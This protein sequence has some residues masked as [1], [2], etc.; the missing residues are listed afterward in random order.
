[1]PERTCPICYQDQNPSSTSENDIIGMS[2]ASGG[3]IGSAQT[4]VANPY[5][6]IPCGCLY[7]FSCIAQRLEA[8]EGEGWICLRCGEI[9]KQCKPWNGD[10]LE[11]VSRTGSGKNVGF[12]EDIEPRESEEESVAGK[13]ED[14]KTPLTPDADDGLQDSSHWSNLEKDSSEDGRNEESDNDTMQ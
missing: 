9:V 10:V 12:V 6:T 14:E 8:E 11:E 1:L 5:E 2:A 3:I 13:Q 7:C 4:D